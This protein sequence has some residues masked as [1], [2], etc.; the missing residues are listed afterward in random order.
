MEREKSIFV[1]FTQVNSQKEPCLV[2]MGDHPK[3]PGSRVN[4]RKNLLQSPVGTRESIFSRVSPRTGFFGWS[5][6]DYTALQGNHVNAYRSRHSALPGSPPIKP[7]RCPLFSNP[8]SSPPSPLKPYHVVFPPP[9]PMR[10]FL[11]ARRVV[12]L[13]ERLSGDIIFFLHWRAE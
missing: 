1:I 12:Q 8:V 9:L 3:K 2:R 4:E 7:S 11:S 5:P 6:S 13:L 10:D